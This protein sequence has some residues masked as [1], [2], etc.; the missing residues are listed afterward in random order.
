MA[1]G[2]RHWSLPFPITG[3]IGWILLHL[4]AARDPALM[5]QVIAAAVPGIAA[6][7]L[8]LWQTRTGPA[9][10][11]LAVVG[12]AGLGWFVVPFF[13]RSKRPPIR[14]LGA[15][16]G[17]LLAAGAIVPFVLNFIP[18]KPA[19]ARDKSIGKANRLCASLW[20]LRPIALQ[21][22]G[23]VMTYVD[24][25]PRLITVTHHDAI[26][27]PYHRNGDQIADV[28]N[29]WR[30]D[31]DQAHRLAAKYRANYVLSCP[32]SSTTTIFDSETPKGFYGQLQRGQ[33]PKWLTPV[34][35]PKDLPFRMWKVVA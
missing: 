5:R 31:A 28:M 21:P 6:S 15:V 8:L 19:T 11:M 18:E 20:G 4:D 17:A 9:S 12:A 29:F 10:Q 27:G 14:I 26:T 13:W 16:L 7:L 22:K 23:V 34:T 35:L 2:S 1:G 30:G 24:L 25:G 33:V 32:G 3:A